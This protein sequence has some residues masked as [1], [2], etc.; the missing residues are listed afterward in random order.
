MQNVTVLYCIVYV[1]L[2]LGPDL[3]SNNRFLRKDIVTLVAYTRAEASRCRPGQRT[4]RQKA[5]FMPPKP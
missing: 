2:S 4:S 5:C 3:G 1:S